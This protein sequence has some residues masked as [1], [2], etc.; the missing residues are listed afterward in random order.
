MQNWWVAPAAHQFCIG[1]VA[2]GVPGVLLYGT[3]PGDGVWQTE[4]MSFDAPNP[5][6]EPVP[7][8]TPGAA[9]IPGN[10]PTPTAPPVE[11]PAANYPPPTTPPAAYP[12]DAYPGATYPAPGYGAVPA[13]PPAPRTSNNA[14]VALVLAILSYLLCPVV[15]SIG[16]LIIANSAKREIDGSNGWIT[17]SGMVTASKVLAWINIALVILVIAVGVALIPLRSSGALH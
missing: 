13:A 15:L 3:Q 8:D 1:G 12:P 14:M 2:P 11:P 5:A 6:D 7:T 9:E 10:Y 17:G 4:S 16:A